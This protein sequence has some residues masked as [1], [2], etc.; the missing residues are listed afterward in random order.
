MT[1]EM[2]QCDDC[3]VRRFGVGRAVLQG[4]AIDFNEVRKVGNDGFPC[5]I[6]QDGHC[7]GRAR[8]V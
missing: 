6:C 2:S 1:Y 4:T 3:V 5:S 8:G 7:V